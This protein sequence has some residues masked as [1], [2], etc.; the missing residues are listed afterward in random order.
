LYARRHGYR[1]VVENGSKYT[2][3]RHPSWFKVPF[4]QSQLACCC[5]WAFFLDS[6]AYMRMDHH[7]LSIPTWIQSINQPSYFSWLLRDNLASTYTA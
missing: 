6:D 5:E 3:D 2:P 1:M 7:R 4:L